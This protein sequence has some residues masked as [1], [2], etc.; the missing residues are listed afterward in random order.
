MPQVVTGTFAAVEGNDTETNV[1]TMWTVL[2]RQPAPVPFAEL[3][4]SHTSFAHTVENI[5][6]LSCLVQGVR[7]V[8]RGSSAGRLGCAGPGL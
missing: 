2:Q 1:A 8:A 6:A 4:C 7:W 3:V 5:F